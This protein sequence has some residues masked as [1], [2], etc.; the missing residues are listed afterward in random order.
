M[1]IMD[2]IGLVVGVLFGFI[3]GVI[4]DFRMVANNLI[5][6][7]NSRKERSLIRK[8]DW[9]ISKEEL[10]NAQLKELNKLLNQRH[11]D[12]DVYCPCSSDYP[13]TDCDLREVSLYDL[14]DELNAFYS[15][16]ASLDQVMIKLKEV[17]EFSV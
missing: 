11:F 14:R 5:N 15:A 1:D 13:N 12:E 2:I 6:Y 7:L 10:S 9:L 4:F 16:K 8:V 17:K 3:I